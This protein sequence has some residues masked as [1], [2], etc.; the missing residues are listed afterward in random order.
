MS[1]FTIDFDSSTFYRLI[2]VHELITMMICFS[3]FSFVSI[4]LQPRFGVSTK[5]RFDVSTLLNGDEFNLAQQTPNE[6]QPLTHNNKRR[7]KTK[8]DAEHIKF[9]L[10][11]DEGF[12]RIPWLDVY[13]PSIYKNKVLES[14]IITFVYSGSDGSIHAVN[15]ETKYHDNKSNPSNGMP[16]S[17]VVEYVWIEEADVDVQGGL[18]MLFVAVLIVAISGM[19]GACS[20]ATQN[21]K[22]KGSPVKQGKGRSPLDISSASNVEGFAKQF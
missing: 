22:G 18:L 17:F 13:N 4:H 12:H 16:E 6:H 20:S 3:S 1:S 5:T 9:S 21:V 10:S 19:V 7:D 11:F 8:D 14:L 15:R 2:V